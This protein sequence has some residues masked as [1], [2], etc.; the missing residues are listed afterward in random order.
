[1][2]SPTEY[3]DLHGSEFAGLRMSSRRVT[4]AAEIAR[5]EYLAQHLDSAKGWFGR[6]FKSLSEVFSFAQQANQAARL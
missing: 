2:T 6:C 3:N 5:A 1:M 4:H